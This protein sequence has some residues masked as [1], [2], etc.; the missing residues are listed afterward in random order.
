MAELSNPQPTGHMRQFCAAHKVKYVHMFSW[1]TCNKIVKPVYTMLQSFA[2]VNALLLKW[3]S[4]MSKFFRK[5]TELP[6]FAPCGLPY[7][8]ADRCVACGWL[9][10]KALIYGVICAQRYVRF[11]GLSCLAQ[12][13]KSYSNLHIYE[14]YSLH[15]ISMITL[16][17]EH[18][19]TI[20][21]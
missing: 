19:K 9:S 1:I 7:D 12:E 2:S 11:I 5:S 10:K 20:F 16:Y 8:L 13:N 6:Y 18:T 21:M 15:L 3:W 17:K 14:I 4:L